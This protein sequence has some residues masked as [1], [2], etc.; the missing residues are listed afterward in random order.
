MSFDV[1]L[2]LFGSQQPEAARQAVAAVLRDLEATGP[3]EFGHYELAIADLQMT[4]STLGEPEP[5]YE[6]V[7]A[8]GLDGPEEFDGCAFFLHAFSPGVAQTIFRI[9]DAGGLTILAAGD[10]GPLVPPSASPA[11]LPQD[12]PEPRRVTSGEDLFTALSA[13][14]DR[15]ARFREHVTRA[16]AARRTASRGLAG[17]IRNLASKARR[18]GRAQPAHVE[19]IIIERRPPRRSQDPGSRPRD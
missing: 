6:R 1:F 8:L 5:Y 13:D 2:E 15:Y 7:T 18:K 16:G 3:D 11:A 10:S 12:L 14:Y 9:A 4:R 17:A 19:E